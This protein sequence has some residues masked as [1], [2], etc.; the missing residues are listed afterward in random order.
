MITETVKKYENE[1]TKSRDKIWPNFVSSLNKALVPG[2]IVGAVSFQYIGGP[3]S[4]LA[5]SVVAAGLAFLKGLLDIQVEVN[6]ARR[7][8]SPAVA[9]LSKLKSLS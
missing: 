2:G 8:A 3:G 7:S 4:V 1:L 9:Y 6:N 5:G